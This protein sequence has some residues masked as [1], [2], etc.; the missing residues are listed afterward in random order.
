MLFRSDPTLQWFNTAAFARNAVGTFGNV[1]KGTLRGP[2]MFS[3]DMGLFKKIPLK[4]ERVGMQFRAEFFNIFNHPML[5]NPAT[6]LT[7]G[8]YGR[9]TQTLANAGATQG[10]ITSGGP[11]IIQLALKMTF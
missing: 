1:G 8:T 5:N 9:I 11:R 4:G 6:T 2:G 3:W 7:S 10:D